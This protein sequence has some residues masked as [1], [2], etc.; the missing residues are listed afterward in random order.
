LMNTFSFPCRTAHLVD[1]I[2]PRLPVPSVMPSAPRRRY[3]QAWPLNSA[4]SVSFNR[5][6]SSRLN[7]WLKPRRSKVARR[8]CLRRGVDQV[9]NGL[10]RVRGHV[11]RGLIR[12]DADA[13]QDALF[14]HVGHALLMC[15][16]RHWDRPVAQ[17]RFGKRSA[18]RWRDPG[19][20]WSGVDPP[21]EP[22]RSMPKSEPNAS[23]PPSNAPH[24]SRPSADVQYVLG[25]DCD[26][27]LIEVQ[28][29]RCASTD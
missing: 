16:S 14:R 19:P 24:L 12:I 29:V 18:H 15:P 11:R 20:C 9:V 8:A 26:D 25:N 17:N 2:G 10:E 22:M 4:E 23:P 1:E 5:F 7:N 13:A 27:L 3:G 28:S 21:L 6:K